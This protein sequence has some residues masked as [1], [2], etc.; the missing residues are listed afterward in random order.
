MLMIIHLFDSF[1]EVDV[2][3]G[4]LATNAVDRMPLDAGTSSA[5]CEM[6]KKI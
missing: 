2:I 1:S 3:S 4:I 6:N 5:L